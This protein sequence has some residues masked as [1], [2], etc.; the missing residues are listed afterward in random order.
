MNNLDDQLVLGIKGIPSVVE[1]KVI[2][3]RMLARQEAN[4]RRDELFKRL[5][6]GM[7]ATSR[8]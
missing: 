4:A 3:Q 7:R 5:P 6:I 8:G 2:R 1:L